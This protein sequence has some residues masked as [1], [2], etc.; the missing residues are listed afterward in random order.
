MG[1]RRSHH[2]YANED[3]WGGR[4]KLDEIIWRVIPDDSARFLALKAGDIHGLEQ[5]TI[6]DLATAAADPELQVLTKPP[7]NTSYLAFNYKIKEFQDP[8]VR[9]AIAHAINKQ[10]AGG[11]LLRQI[12]PRLPRP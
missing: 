7:L 8:K 12:R 1:R 6:E 3:Y 11:E 4:P 9:E 2:R 5:A 10:A